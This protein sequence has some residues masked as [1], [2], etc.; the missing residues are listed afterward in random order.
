MEAHSHPTRLVA[1]TK[2]CRITQRR[3][4]AAYSRTLKTR[5]S[6]MKCSDRQFWNL[7]KKIGGIAKKNAAAAPSAE[8]LVEHFADKMGN[9]KGEQEAEYIPADPMRVPLVSWKIR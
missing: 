9:A 4:F 7:T 5:L 1:A 6:K 8:A 2:R 3:A